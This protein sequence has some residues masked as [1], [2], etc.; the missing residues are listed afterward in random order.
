MQE[1]GRST[2]RVSE[3]SEIRKDAIV[4]GKFLGVPSGDGKTQMKEFVRHTSQGSRGSSET[5][6]LNYSDWR[7][8]AKKIGNL[9]A[10]RGNLAD[11]ASASVRIHKRLGNFRGE[12]KASGRLSERPRRAYVV[13]TAETPNLRQRSRLDVKRIVF[14]RA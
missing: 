14:G 5:F 8:W 4:Y 9:K 13:S 3:V 7:P 6:D 1:R 12:K 2:E 11:I 10:L